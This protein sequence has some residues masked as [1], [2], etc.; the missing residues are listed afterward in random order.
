M[1]RQGGATSELAFSSHYCAVDDPDHTTA[2]ACTWMGSGLRVFDVRDPL[3]AREIAYYVPPGRPDVIRGNLLKAGI[4]PNPNLDATG[5]PVRWRQTAGGWDLW[6]ASA[7]N[8]LQV[9]RL[10]P[11]AYPLARA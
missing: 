1:E 2:V 6:F 11:G 10:D 3:H 9:V 8:G 4:L 5:S 7:Q